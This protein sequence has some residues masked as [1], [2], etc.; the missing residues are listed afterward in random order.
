MYFVS[1][2]CLLLLLLQQKLRAGP[3]WKAIVEQSNQLGFHNNVLFLLNLFLGL[4]F[5]Y[6]K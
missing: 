1:L 2:K 5:I 4:P 6:E 3:G